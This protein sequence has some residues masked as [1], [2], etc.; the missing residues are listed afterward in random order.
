MRFYVVA[1]LIS[2]WGKQ[3]REILEKQLERWVTVGAIALVVGI[4]IAIYAL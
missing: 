3:A 1:F 2:R 4:A